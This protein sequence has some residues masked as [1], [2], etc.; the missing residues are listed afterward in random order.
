MSIGDPVGSRE[1]MEDGPGIGA[2]V[3]RDARAQRG[4]HRLPRLRSDND[5]GSVLSE[6]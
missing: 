4:Q 2:N 6:M 1:Q 5:V 3:G